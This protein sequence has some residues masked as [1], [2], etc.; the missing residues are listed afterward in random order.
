MDN[1]RQVLSC[2]Y[3]PI[4][5]CLPYLHPIYLP[6]GTREHRCRVL[7]SPTPPPS[8]SDIP[9]FQ[10]NRATPENAIASLPT[11]TDDRTIGRVEVCFCP[12][13][14]VWTSRCLHKLGR[15]AR[16]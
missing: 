9:R 12:E 8:V 5:M 4:P 7:L 15:T 6:K 16:S 13:Q 14:R 3:S 10:A 2:L 1:S 11:H